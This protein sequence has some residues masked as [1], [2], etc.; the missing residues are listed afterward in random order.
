MA[1]MRTTQFC[2]RMTMSAI[3]NGSRRKRVAAH[4]DRAIDVECFCDD[5]AIGIH[6][7][8]MANVAP[9]IARMG[10]AWWISMAGGAGTL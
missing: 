9:C 1:Y 8:A 3:R 4:F 2:L 6:H 10:P 7:I 5:N